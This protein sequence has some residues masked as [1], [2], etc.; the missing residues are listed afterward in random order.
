MYYILVKLGK[1]FCFTNHDG[2]VFS[3]VLGEINLHL[4]RGESLLRFA[5]WHSMVVRHPGKHLLGSFH[6]KSNSNYSQRMTAVSQIWACLESVNVQFIIFLV[7]FKK[8]YKFLHQI[9]YVL[10]LPKVGDKCMA[11]IQFSCNDFVQV[12]MI[13]VVVNLHRADS[14]GTRE[15]VH[16]DKRLCFGVV[17]CGHKCC[18]YTT[19]VYNSSWAHVSAQHEMC[20][21]A[22]VWPQKEITWNVWIMMLFP[23]VLFLKQ[24]PQSF[25]Q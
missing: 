12:E 10:L 9:N 23:E 22:I 25:W 7:K 20:Y 14:V 15:Y 2:S 16:M 17:H 6:M 1:S 13:P 21:M 24:F 4:D 18:F 19:A 5:H 3:S 11:W 8:N